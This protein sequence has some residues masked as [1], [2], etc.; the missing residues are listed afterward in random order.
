MEGI[1]LK[2]EFSFGNFI[3][4]KIEKEELIFYMEANYSIFAIQKF[5]F[6]VNDIPQIISEG[7]IYDPKEEKNKYGEF[8]K[9]V[10]HY[11]WGIGNKN[12][13]DDCYYFIIVEE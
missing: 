8:L 10:K 13:Y 4:K 9:A 3:Y 1:V 2:E 11:F 7:M 5:L 12:N 6:D